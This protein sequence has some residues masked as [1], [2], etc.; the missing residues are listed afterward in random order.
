MSSSSPF[1][2]LV[3]CSIC[4]QKC[5]C[6][7]EPL[8]VR[9]QMCYFRHL[10]PCGL[11]LAGQAWVKWD[12]PTQGA[13]KE[14]EGNTITALQWDSLICSF[15]LSG[16]GR[17]PT[18]EH[19]KM[20][21]QV[22]P[23]PPPALKD[24]PHATP[25][26]SS[27]LIILWVGERMVDSS[28]LTCIELKH[29]HKMNSWNRIKLSIQNIIYNQI[30]IKVQHL[31]SS[32]P[33]HNRWLLCKSLSWIIREKRHLLD[34]GNTTKGDKSRHSYQDVLQFANAKAWMPP[35]EI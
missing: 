17:K 20:Q 18:S 28:L 6:I 27:A 12:W 2:T 11:S 29:T 34:N 8:R 32:K 21:K 30:P 24:S 19:R 14:M 33:S 9:F 16:E 13:H 26:T 5:L 31:T 22:T 10:R 25:K 23:T 15:L 7:L 3:I 1:P 4:G 35:N